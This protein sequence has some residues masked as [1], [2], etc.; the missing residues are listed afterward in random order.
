MRQINYLKHNL[1]NAAKRMCVLIFIMWILIPVNAIAQLF[2]GTIKPKSITFPST[3]TLKQNLTY[4][5][6][7]VYDQNYVPWTAP[8]A[9]ATTD[10]NVNPDGTN[11]AIIANVQGSIST[12]GVSIIIKV[13]SITGSGTLPA[14]SNS[15]DI[16]A[17]LTE[18]GIGRTLTLSW[19]QQAF[20]VATT[21]ITATL[22]AVGGT[23]NVKKLDMNA[24]VGNDYLGVLIGTLSY[25]YT[26]TNS[27]TLKVYDLAPIPDKMLG[28][29][30]NAGS[31]TTHNFLY[32]PMMCEDGKIWLNY[33]LG[34]DYAN[35]NNASFVLINPTASLTDYHA[36][37]SVFQYGRKP[38]G[39][40]L[41]TWTSSSA[42]TPVYGVIQGP[43]TEPLSTALW[44]NDNG[45]GSWRTPYQLGSL[46][47]NVSAPNNPCPDSFRIPSTTEL[48][49]VVTLVTTCNDMLTG[50]T[51]MCS[52]GVRSYYNPPYSPGAG[53][54]AWW[55]NQTQ[56]NQYQPWYWNCNNPTNLS[57]FD[58]GSAGHG[59][60]CIKN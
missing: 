37:G 50:P 26:K 51:K 15:V 53:G 55:A 11:E 54:G 49:A 46:W 18:D 16:P 41:I 20:T 8:V 56:S 34:A 32:L 48:K 35:M 43:L 21:Q 40:E 52:T 6:A 58:Y 2:G 29:A 38:D 33:N 23:L 30:D 14:Y 5:V 45:T 47:A 60:R 22:A 42:G 4:T 44:I 59:V 19:P 39:H 10:T 1:S 3:I 7:S 17:S 27:T 9:A 28:L 31:L 25:P 12:T 36:Y 57:F 24:G 13:V